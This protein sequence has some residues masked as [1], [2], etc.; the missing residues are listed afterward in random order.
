MRNNS[1]KLVSIILLTGSLMAGCSTPEEAGISVDTTPASIPVDAITLT[2]ANAL[3]VTASAYSSSRIADPYKTAASPSVAATPLSILNNSASLIKSVVTTKSSET[4]N[5]KATTSNCSGTGTIVTNWTE[6]TG[7]TTA[8]ATGTISFNNCIESVIKTNG[9][10][11]FTLTASLTT[12]EYYSTVYG[13]LNIT[14]SGDD[15][16]IYG[17]NISEYGDDAFPHPFDRSVHF[18]VTGL[19][20]VGGGY[21]YQTITPYSG[22]DGICAYT[23]SIRISGANNSRLLLTFLNANQVS[24][25][26]DDGDATNGTGYAALSGSPY[27]TATTTGAC[28]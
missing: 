24:I 22:Y 9:V 1:N 8:T 10:L 2:Q 5:Y 26:L 14:M 7:S 12:D 16:R 15:F 4:G 23:G 13:T 21:L 20:T 25:E 17:I 18:A 27:N 6:S 11:G 28:Y 19:N 3:D